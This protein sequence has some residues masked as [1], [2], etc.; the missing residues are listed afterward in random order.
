MNNIVSAGK[1]LVL[2]VVL[3]QVGC[4]ALLGLLFWGLKGFAAGLSGLTGGLIVAV[5]SAIF[6]GRMFAP[7]IAPAGKLYRAMIAGESLKWLWYV[8]AIWAALA[9]FRLDPL[10]LI[11]GLI[12]AQFAFF[13]LV[14]MKRG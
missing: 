11:C 2:R 9:R 10:P 5:G 1:R 13:G 7:G 8:F 4:A 12:I 6:G 14:G 3:L